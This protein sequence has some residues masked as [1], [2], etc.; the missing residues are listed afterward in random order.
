[1]YS[2]KQLALR[3]KILEQI[4]VHRAISRIDIS[5]NTSITPATTSS[6]TANLLKEG[7]IKEIGEEE[8]EIVK[9][10]RKKILLHINRSKHYLIGMELSEK[11]ISFVTTDS[12]GEIV[13]KK[14]VPITGRMIQERGSQL[15]L[16]HLLPFIASLPETTSILALGLGLPGRYLNDFRIT[17][18]NPIWQDFD[19]KLLADS[20]PYPLYFSNNVNCM[21]L[22][23]RLFFSQGYDQNFVFFHLGRGMH[24]SYMYNG[25][26]YGKNNS[27]IGEIG[28]TIVQPE[29]ER[30]SCGKRGCLQ[31]YA[32]ESWLIKKAQL[33]FQNA[34]HSLFQNLVQKQEDIGL[35]TVLT[36][37]ELGD[38]GAILLVNTALKYI[39]QSILNL[40]MLIDSQIIYLHSPLL[41]KPPLVELL[42]QAIHLE[43][44]VLSNQETPP[45]HIIPYSLF[46]G[47]RSAAALALY[48][49]LLEY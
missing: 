38:S 49:E 18:D 7:Y 8:N 24:C 29:G 12:G 17:T 2:K 1:M 28:H 30:C 21:A 40:N 42:N 41:T 5:K 36:A 6:I 39:A 3:A 45:I 25:T 15:I 11:Y 16:D 13:Q 33:L 9:A 31:T 32:G 48:K 10:G 23:Q 44:K 14:N 26:I 4:Y 27:I 47:A 22:A 43:P 34:D 19:L 37:Y 46:T 35:E 20:L